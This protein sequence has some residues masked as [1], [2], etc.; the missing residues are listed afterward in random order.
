M[1]ASE[2]MIGNYVY[3]NLKRIVIIDEI[4]P[5]HLIFH[6]SNGAKVKHTLESFKPIPLTEEWLFNLG[7]EKLKS[8]NEWYVIK[9]K[10]FEFSIHIT[11]YEICF[12]SG[13]VFLK[14]DFKYIHKIQNLY[15]ALTGEQLKL[16]Q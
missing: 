11:G 8:S 6:L 14:G 15:F 9:N 12:G 3:D 5:E 4:R 1:E 7:F 16:Q 13:N 2:L 10:G